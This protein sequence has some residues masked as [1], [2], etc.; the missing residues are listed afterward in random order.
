MWECVYVCINTDESTV[1]VL[2]QI[3]TTI[4]EQY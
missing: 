4:W 3:M 1:P 2:E